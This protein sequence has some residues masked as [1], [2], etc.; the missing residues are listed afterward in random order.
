MTDRQILIV[1][2]ERSI[3]ST[4]TQALEPLGLPIHSAVNGEEALE[5]LR[6][7]EFALVFLDLKMPGIDGVEVLCRIREEWPATRVIVI[8]AHGTIG[9]AVEAMKAGAVDFLEKPFSPADVREHATAVLERETHDGQLAVDYRS[10][11]E[12][13]R[14]HDSDRSFDAARTCVQRAVAADPG[15]PEAYNL[16]GALLE[17]GGNR[18]EAQKYYR[19]ALDIEPTFEP[20]QANLERTVAGD[21]RGVID[22]RPDEHAENPVQ[23]PGR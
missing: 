4:I 22:L 1:D 12:M 17:L 3:R 19:A 6:E 9:S 2:D 23:G 16:L 15:R 5:K 8:S 14:R 21:K 13:A 7:S 18:L 11:I 20:A 10:L